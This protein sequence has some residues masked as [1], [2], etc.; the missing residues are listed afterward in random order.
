MEAKPARN[1]QVPEKALWLGYA[2]LLPQLLALAGALTQTEWRWMAQA[3]GFAYAAL[4]FSFLGGVWWGQAITSKRSASWIFV[5]SVVASLIALGLFLPWVVG[6]EW[7][8]PSLLWLGLLIG[9]S[10][11]VD[12]RIGLAEPAFMRL[13]THL[14]VGLGALTTALGAVALS[15]G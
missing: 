14:S 6:W 15:T 1:G 9:L 4:I 10:P 11:L 7:P 8:G 3:A 5:V 13:R 2:G 12:R